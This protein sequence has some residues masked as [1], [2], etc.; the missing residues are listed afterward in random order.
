[1]GHIPR[2]LVDH[3]GRILL[4]VIFFDGFRSLGHIIAGFAHRGHILRNLVD[5]PDRILLRVIFFDGVRS[6]GHIIAGFAHLGHLAHPDPPWMVGIFAIFSPRPR[7]NQRSLKTKKKTALS[8]KTFQ[9]PRPENI[10]WRRL[11]EARTGSS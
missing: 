5:H 6:L 2:N 3:L 10:S 8:R 7:N 4:R 1:M 9:K 11:L